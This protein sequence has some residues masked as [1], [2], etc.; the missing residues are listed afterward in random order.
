MSSIDLKEHN[1]ILGNLEKMADGTEKH[2]AEPD[3][4]TTLKPESIR[5][6]KTHLDGTRQV[7]DDADGEAHRK[8]LEYDAEKKNV[9]AEYSKF[10]DALYGKYGKRNPILTD[11]GVQ[12][13]KSPGVKGPRKKNTTQT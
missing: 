7:Y 13:Q 10:V 12:P 5:N 9:K 6:M 4:P 3:F 11:F 2:S 1:G 8:Y